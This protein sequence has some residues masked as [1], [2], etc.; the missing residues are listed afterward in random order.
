MLPHRQSQLDNL[1][2]RF[3]DGRFLLPQ[4]SPLENLCGLPDFLL[5]QDFEVV[6]NH[7]FRT[8]YLLRS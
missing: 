1:D 3:E 7:R 8:V 5:S 4:R 6:P 2:Y